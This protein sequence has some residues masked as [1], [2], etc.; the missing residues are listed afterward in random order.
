MSVINVPRQLLSAG[1]ETM[2]GAQPRQGVLIGY[3]GV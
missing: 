3:A 2:P 1:F